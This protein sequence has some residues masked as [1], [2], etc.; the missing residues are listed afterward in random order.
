MKKDPRRTP[1]PGE[2]HPVSTGKLKNAGTSREADATSPDAVSYTSMVQ[3]EVGTTPEEIE[4]KVETIKA[5]TTREDKETPDQS[6]H[7]STIWMGNAGSVS[8]VDSHMTSRR[9]TA[10]RGEG[11]P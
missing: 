4:D 6:Q 1:I 11:Q 5:H 7:V 8:I 9:Q 10:A 3:Q 2:E